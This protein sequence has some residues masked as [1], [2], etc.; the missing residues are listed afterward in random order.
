MMVQ[1]PQTQSRQIRPRG[2]RRILVKVSIQSVHWGSTMS[3]LADAALTE[4]IKEFPFKTAS[5]QHRPKLLVQHFYEDCSFLVFD[6]D[7][8][9]YDSAM[10]HETKRNNLDVWVV[11]FGKMS[12]KSVRATP[13]TQARVNRDVAD[14]HDLHG[15]GSEPPFVTD[16]TRDDRPCYLNPRSASSRITD[17]VSD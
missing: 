7:H 14:A 16:Y 12:A 10:A 3:A 1:S 4:H 8:F 17:T 9:T 6:V 15:W 2:P 5:E 11:R 13:G